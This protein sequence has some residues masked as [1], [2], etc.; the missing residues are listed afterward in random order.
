MERI[1]AIITT[2]AIITVTLVITGCPQKPIIEEEK[3]EEEKVNPI[4]QNLIVTRTESNF[5]TFSWDKVKT[6]E[7]YILAI[8]STDK[9]PESFISTTISKDQTS[10]TD[11]G[12]QGMQT[13]YYKVRSIIAGNESEW[14]AILEATTSGLNAP[15]QVGLKEYSQSVVRLHWKESQGATEYQIYRTTGEAKNF[16]PIDTTPDNTTGDTNTFTDLR[17]SLEPGVSVFYRIKAINTHSS[18][19]SSP[20]P[21]IEVMIENNIPLNFK[22]NLFSSY[23]ITLQWDKLDSIKPVFYNIY[24]AASKNGV[25]TKVANKLYNTTVYKNPSLQ[26]ATQYFYKIS[27]TIDGQESN[28]SLPIEGVTPPIPPNFYETSN[29]TSTTMQFK[30]GYNPEEMGNKI[31]GY[32]LYKI[33]QNGTSIDLGKPALIVS[34][35]TINTQLI[36]SLNPGTEYMFIAR[37]YILNENNDYILSNTPQ[38]PHKDFTKLPKTEGLLIVADSTT[39]NSMTLEWDPV[40]LTNP[41]TGTKETIV[42][43]Q[44][45]RA[46]SIN[47]SDIMT[48]P[49][50]T[51]TLDPK[52]N[53]FSYTDSKL[54]SFTR[55]YYK[56]VATKN[57]SNSKV[58]LGEENNSKD[59]YTKLDEPTIVD[60]VGIIR[61]D[62]TAQFNFKTVREGQEY[63]LERSKV[64]DFSD[65]LVTK[66]ISGNSALAELQANDTSLSPYNKYF[67]RLKAKHSIAPPSSEIVYSAPSNPIEI[68]TRIKKSVMTE[69]TNVE[70]KTLTLNWNSVK[71]YS[72]ANKIEIYR[73]IPPSTE[74]TQK[75]DTIDRKDAW[76]TAITSYEDKT[77]LPSTTYYYKIRVTDNGSTDANYSPYSD[78]LT[79]T[80]KM[81]A[82]EGVTL[83][84]TYT[85]TTTKAKI[86]WNA[87]KLAATNN[88]EYQVFVNDKLFKTRTTAT[89]M[90]LD[91]LNIGDKNKVTVIAYNIDTT[92]ETPGAESIPY[93]VYTCPGVPTLNTVAQITNNKNQMKVSWTSTG[94]VDVFYEI[95]RVEAGGTFPT[96]TTLISTQDATSFDDKTS[97]SLTN[98]SYKV[99]AVL[100]DSSG[101]N[102]AESGFSD[103]ITEMSGLA[104]PT[105]FSA[106]YDNSSKSVK[107]TWNPVSSTE[108]YILY[109]DGIVYKRITGATSFEDKTINARTSYTYNIAASNISE[110][111]VSYNSIDSTANVP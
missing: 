1:K 12:L 83:D 68:H 60:P 2:L 97:L 56:I 29:P 74:P 4:P 3:K 32:F 26:P 81:A 90:E 105:G 91:K 99:K 88:I 16:A 27:T 15:T 80:T 48:I 71:N 55:Y 8:S 63:V 58:A 51:M 39:K 52:T 111:N 33:E 46:T 67:Y 93:Y 107:I 87:H 69:S 82:V 10:Y 79:V 31:L 23:D 6:A 42:D 21:I 96:T 76:G 53:K 86:K 109:R 49:S 5:I 30:W 35:K 61:T 64:S 75:I 70:G 36:T 25:Y 19:E 95:Y 62:T 34:A 110:T 85:V 11:T 17:P 94:G 89:S 92:P 43:Y 18:T 47:F 59:G 38:T 22:V 104:T 20:S 57:M 108:K 72:G 84:T 102:L 65:T 24:R 77:V 103:P 78:I 40:I 73:S 44:I 106:S 45:K 98:Y 100:K 41:S 66:T 28:L 7:S 13:Y 54:E 101:N 14:S 37:A 9:Q 50:K